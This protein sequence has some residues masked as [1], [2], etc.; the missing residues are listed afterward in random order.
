MIKY[1]DI[2]ED[3]NI[4]HNLSLIFF[5]L[6]RAF[7]IVKVNP[8]FFCIFIL[9]PPLI[10]FTQFAHEAFM[11][12]HEGHKTTYT[13]ERLMS[14]LMKPSWLCTGEAVMCTTSY[15]V[16]LLDLHFCLE[17]PSFALFTCQIFC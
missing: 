1:K 10:P 3:G 16:L 7:K 13:H 17:K 12:I 4:G 15:R 14:M 11:S 9:M 6:N 2:I 5:F 8:K